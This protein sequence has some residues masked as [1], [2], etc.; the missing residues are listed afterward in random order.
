VRPASVE[1]IEGEVDA[2]AV[3]HNT[4]GAEGVCRVWNAL[5]AEALREREV[6]RFSGVRSPSVLLAFLRQLTD[7]R[8][9][10]P[11]GLARSGAQGTEAV[12]RVLQFDREAAC[13]PLR[14]EL[15]QQCAGQS[16]DPL[17]ELSSIVAHHAE[18]CWG[19]ACRAKAGAASFPLTHGAANRVGR[20]R[21]YGNAI[22]GPVAQGFI[23]A[24]MASD[25]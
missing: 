11:V 6:G 15:A 23:E 4:N 22:V 14:R 2:W 10:F 18:E 16:P 19:D 17:R 24:V 7:Q 13:T 9:R 1:E 12:V 8:W 20:L 3:R 21:G 25:L 5:S